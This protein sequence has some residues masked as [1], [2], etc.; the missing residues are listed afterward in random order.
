MRA[1]LRH[2]LLGFVAESL[3]FGA[4]I[5]GFLVLYTGPF[6]A[7]S[8]AIATPPASTLTQASSISVSTR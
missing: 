2:G 1:E 7:P 3:L 5:I 8:S 6:T 4:I